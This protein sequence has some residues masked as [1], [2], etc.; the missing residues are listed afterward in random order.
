MASKTETW[1]MGKM[2]ATYTED[3]AIAREL[4]TIAGMG[5]PAVYMD[6]GLNIFAWQFMY[7]KRMERGVEITVSAAKRRRKRSSSHWARKNA[8]DAALATCGIT[9][10][11]DYPGA[12]A[13]NGKTCSLHRA[14]WEAAHGPIPKGYIIHHQNGD[15]G[16][17]ALANLVCVSPEHHSTLHH[18]ASLLAGGGRLRPAAETLGRC[19]TKRMCRRSALFQPA[20]D[21]EYAL[22]G[23]VLE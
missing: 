3:A 16:D 9:V 2:L 14:R 20:D 1:A 15:K 5:K 21:E 18:V 10:H 7:P 13:R 11:N 19:A 23:A 22:A 6:K 12:R 17:F 4:A 8:E